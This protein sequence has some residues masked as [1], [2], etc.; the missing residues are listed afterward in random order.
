MLEQIINKVKKEPLRFALIAAFILF[1]TQ[2]FSLCI[3][4]SDDYYYTLFTKN[5]MGEF[6]RLTIDH[7]Q[8]INGRALVHFF[9]QIALSLP[10]V[11]RA[12]LNAVI[13]FSSCLFANA[14]F[15]KAEKSAAFMVCTFALLLL[16][17]KGIIKEALMWTSGFYNYVFP[18][19][20]TFIALYLVKNNSKLCFVFAF[21][22]GATTE[23]WGFVA[24]VMLAAF[25][26]LSKDDKK[27]TFFTPVFLSLAGYVTIFL[28]PATMSRIFTSGNTNLSSS[29]IDLPGLSR[30][31][32]SENSALVPIILFL[33]S[34]LFLA[35][36]KK[37]RFKAFYSSVL[38]IFLL[39]TLPLH[40]SYLTAFVIFMCYLVLCIALFIS[41]KNITCATLLTG[42][43][44]AIIIMLPTNTYDW[45]VAF[46]GTFLIMLCT[47]FIALPL[48]SQRKLR[49]CALLILTVFSLCAFAPSYIGFYRNHLTEKA[50]LAAIKNA[51]ITKTL[52]YSIDYDKNYAMRQM[53]NDGWF[54]KQFVALYNLE[55]CQ[56]HLT[57][58]NAKTI[59]YNGNPLAA[60]ALF[61]NGEYYIPLRSFITAAKGEVSDNAP[62]T[63]TLNGKTLTY[64]DGILMYKDLQGNEKYLIADENKLADWYTLYL[65]L[66]I[67]ED[68]FNIDIIIK[69]TP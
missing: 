24:I 36:I 26:F 45:R 37:G 6:I 40:K 27:P 14:V 66:P 29:L 59:F 56:I 5:G 65:K 11:L 55:D 58:K 53:F 46:P 16:F 7:F 47:V 13:L 48:L 63:F 52:E 43:V 49:V 25:I 4:Q 35:I 31:F 61:E 17:G 2:L 54:Y 20:I 42:A 38:P 19:L 67:V 15:G 34:T 33:V 50:N 64:H 1:F 9:A 39:I 28:S 30:V 21:L 60:K 62:C 12:V 23:Q 32:L 57:S 10:L 3:L 69:E 18:A 8:A 51:H 68:A 22:A 41:E 44:A